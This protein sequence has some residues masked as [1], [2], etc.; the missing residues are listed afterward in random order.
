MDEILFGI[1]VGFSLCGFFLFI[2]SFH[3]DMGN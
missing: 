1:S 3:D 2:G